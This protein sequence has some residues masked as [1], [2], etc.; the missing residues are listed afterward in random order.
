MAGY[1]PQ[2]LFLKEAVNFGAQRDQRARVAVTLD[3]IE[4][5]RRES[6]KDF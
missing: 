4:A 1:Q 5:N 6:L 3:Q 2:D